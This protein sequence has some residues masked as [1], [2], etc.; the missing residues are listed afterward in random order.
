M[1]AGQAPRESPRML[2]SRSVEKAGA[3]G[4]SS[5]A[6]SMWPARTCQAEIMDLAHAGLGSPIFRRKV[7]G[8]GWEAR[9]GAGLAMSQ[10]GRGGPEHPLRR[11]R[12]IGFC[13]LPASQVEK[14][15]DLWLE[16]QFDALRREHT[17]TLQGACQDSRAPHSPPA[18]SPPTSQCP[19]GFVWGHGDAAPLLHGVV[20]LRRGSLPQCLCR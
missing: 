11:V 6:G 16:E 14:G 13:H 5:R 15:K 18:H 10:G 8:R 3:A 20:V 2:T 4:G 19:S 12:H 9:S 1:P 7:L 17:E